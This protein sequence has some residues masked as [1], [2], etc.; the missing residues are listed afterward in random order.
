MK[1]LEDLL[2]KNDDGKFVN[3]NAEAVNRKGPDH[4]MANVKDLVKRG[5]FT[6]MENGKTVTPSDSE[7]R[8]MYEKI[9]G[10]S[11]VKEPTVKEAK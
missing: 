8:A 11:V 3:V 1:K 5:E 7:I 6:Y 9:T 2:I 10:I 4:F